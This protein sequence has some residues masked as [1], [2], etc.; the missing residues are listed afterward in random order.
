MSQCLCFYVLNFYVKASEK[1]NAIREVEFKANE[2][3]KLNLFTSTTD[4]N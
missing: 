2:M 4:T 1:F 3:V